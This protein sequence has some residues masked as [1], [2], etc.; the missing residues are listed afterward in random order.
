MAY[1]GRKPQYKKKDYGPRKNE[2]IKV[3]EVMLIDEKG[4]SHGVV[5]TDK[6]REMAKKVGLDLVEVGATTKPPVCKIMDYS[7]YVYEQNKKK[8]AGGAK[9]RVKRMKEFKF[10]PNIEGHDIDTR[11][12][13][14]KQYLDKGHQVRITMWRKGR[15][16][17]DQARETFKEILTLFDDYSTIEPAYKSE[18]RKIF[19]TFK[20]D[21]KKKGSTKNKQISGKKVQD[22]Q[23]KGKPKA[24]DKVQQKQSKPLEDKK[25]KKSKKKSA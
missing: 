10:T 24:E 12:R 19:I 11:V 16:S 15:Q 9:G 7:K 20:S 3:P 5:K 14:A 22:K 4:E 6:A 8:K 2:W 18:G 13:R 17:M 1:Q 23:T 25:V 21:G